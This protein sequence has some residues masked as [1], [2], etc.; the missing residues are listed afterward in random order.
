[1]VNRDPLIEDEAVALPRALL[2]RH[3]FDVLQ[4]AAAQVIHLFEALIQHVGRR[5]LA[6]YSARAEHGY[7]LML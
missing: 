6:T 5:L 1:M 4:D 3:R 7:P 2:F